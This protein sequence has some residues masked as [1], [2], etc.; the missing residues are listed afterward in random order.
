L[1]CRTLIFSRH[2][3]IQMFARSIST[4]AVSTAVRIGEVVEEYPNDKPFPSV[5][6]LATVEGRSLHVV[7]AQTAEQMECIVVTVYEPDPKIW[8]TDFKR[9][10]RK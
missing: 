10:K 5:L 6:L 1:I 3:V 4:D 9:K 7:L 2:A 8:D